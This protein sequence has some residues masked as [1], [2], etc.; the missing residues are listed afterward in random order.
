M[1]Y[2]ICALYMLRGEAIAKQL[3]DEQFNGKTKAK[4]SSRI[5]TLFKK[6]SK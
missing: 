2:Q 1:D 6:I 3:M 5:K 4:K